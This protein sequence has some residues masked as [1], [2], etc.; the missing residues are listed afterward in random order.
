MNFQFQKPFTGIEIDGS[1]IKMV[2]VVKE[3]RTWRLINCKTLS[4]PADV[5]ELSYKE[6][7]VIDPSLF[8]D[9]VRGVLKT[10]KK[11]VSRIGLSLPNEVVKVT[12]HRFNGL[13][14]SEAKIEQ[15]IRWKEKAS[16]PFPIEKA[17]INTSMF[18]QKDTGERSYLTAIAFHD[19]I[20]DYEM[21]FKRMKVNPEVIHP[22]GINQINF[23][24]SHL[25]SKGMTSFLGLF[26]KYFT[27]FV[28]EDSQLIFFRGKRRSFSFVHFLQEIDM[29]I[30]LFKRDY[31]AKEIEKLYF[32]S[33]VGFGKTLEQGL[34]TMGEMPIA[35]VHH[36]ELISGD[37][38]IAGQKGRGLSS[39]A[40]AIGAAQSLA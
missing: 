33:Q 39:Y 13:K 10:S 30:E 17:K 9:M 34:R 11:R 4:I 20:F 22:S 18:V 19:V 38:E 7:N 40:A 15:L 21:H 16:L 3:K 35:R 25:G 36:E 26:E 27:F 6:E 1:F 2:Q 37:A 23:Y 5:L 31:P 32:G 24:L 12:I 29:T 8:R 28:F 14:E